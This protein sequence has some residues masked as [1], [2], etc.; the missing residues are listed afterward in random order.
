[1]QLAIHRDNES[2]GNNKALPGCSSGCLV[3]SLVVILIGFVVLLVVSILIGQAIAEF[4]E[5]VR[6]FFDALNPWNWGWNN[7]RGKP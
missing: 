1:M 4:F 3:V 6:E 5:G 2:I 7:G